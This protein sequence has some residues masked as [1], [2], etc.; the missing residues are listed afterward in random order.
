MT[1][2]ESHLVHYFHKRI[3]N[4]YD[5]MIRQEKQSEKRNVRVQPYHKIY[6]TKNLNN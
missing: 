4:R 6:Q 1:F 3:L 5:V 2:K